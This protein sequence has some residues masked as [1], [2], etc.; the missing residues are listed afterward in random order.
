MVNVC[1]AV[2]LAETAEGDRV[3]PS[4]TSRAM[5]PM[6]VLVLFVLAIAGPGLV[7]D[8]FRSFQ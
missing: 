5:L 4:R 2:V 7:E 1:S 8:M 3:A 6:P